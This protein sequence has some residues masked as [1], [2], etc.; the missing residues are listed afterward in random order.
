LHTR[1]SNVVDQAIECIFLCQ[2]FQRTLCLYPVSQIDRD[3][4]AWKAWVI[5]VTGNTHHLMSAGCQHLR[6]S[7]T[8]TLAGARDQKRTW[9]HV[10]Y[11]GSW[12]AVT[13]TS[14][15]SQCVFR[16][17]GPVISLKK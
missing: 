17:S 3:Q 13:R 5:G 11:L 16:A 6:E 15:K 12:K 10:E 2:L 7:A 8:D 4:Y 1:Q 14:V 9:S